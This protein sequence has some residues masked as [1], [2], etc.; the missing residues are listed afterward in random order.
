MYIILSYTSYTCRQSTPFRAYIK[1]KI[2]YYYKI[3]ILNS[4]QN[5]ST[6]SI[7]IKVC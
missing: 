4:L 6:C 1:I 3:F 2:C 7:Q 5:K